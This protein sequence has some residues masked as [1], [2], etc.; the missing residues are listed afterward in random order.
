MGGGEREKM[1]DKEGERGRGKRQMRI[2]VQGVQEQER[3]GE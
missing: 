3:Q 2:N 1:E